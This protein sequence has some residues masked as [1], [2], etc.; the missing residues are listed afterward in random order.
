VLV[1]NILP[2]AHLAVTYIVW[3]IAS[4]YLGG[5]IWS[6]FLAIFFGVLI[7]GDVV[8]FGS[9]HRQ[10]ILHSVVIWPILGIILYIVHVDY[11]WTPIFAVIH[12]AMDSL[13]WGV[14]ALYPFSSNIF[15]PRILARR[16]RLNP[17]KNMIIE[18]FVEYVSNR[19]FLV[20]EIV[21]CLSAL[22]IF[23]FA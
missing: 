11:F 12:I 15:G 19:M 10:S 20:A 5:D 16:S 17:G 6:L 14:Y 18:F 9:R 21:L 8:L 23:L 13:D 4:R 1:N 3:W 7:D 22:T 2:T